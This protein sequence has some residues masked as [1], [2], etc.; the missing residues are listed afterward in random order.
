MKNASI[1]CHTQTLLRKILVVDD[2]PGLADLAVVLL[3]AHGLGVIVGNSDK[4][5]IEI[6]VRD[7][8]IDAIF[9]TLSCPGWTNRSSG[10]LVRTP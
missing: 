4:E 5:A 6:L 9:R 3:S 1:R 7:S 8:E 10:T 2:E